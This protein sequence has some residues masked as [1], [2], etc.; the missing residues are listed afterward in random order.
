MATRIIR[1]QLP[2]RIVRVEPSG[3]VLEVETMPLPEIINVEEFS[4]LDFS[5]AEADFIIQDLRDQVSDRIIRASIGIK[6]NP[7]L[8]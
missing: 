1:V 8:K 2:G 5:D 4:K 7:E 3:I 6:R